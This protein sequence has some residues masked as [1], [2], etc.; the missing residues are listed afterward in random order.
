MNTLKTTEL[1]TL[2]RWILYYMNYIFQ[3]F[4]L[5]RDSPSYTPRTGPNSPHIHYN[6][7]GDNGLI[8]DLICISLIM[9]ETEV[10]KA[11]FFSWNCLLWGFPPLFNWFVDFSYSFIQ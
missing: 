4:F 1:V 3:F 7:I 2:K 10:K 8:A 9:S 5:K 11:F 6:L